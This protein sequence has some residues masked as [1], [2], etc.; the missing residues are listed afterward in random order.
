MRPS[1]AF[2]TI[3]LLAAV[4][5]L[6]DAVR[7][8]LGALAWQRVSTWAEAAA[9]VLGAGWL[10][11]Q[12]LRC[13]REKHVEARLLILPVLLVLAGGVFSYTRD[14]L[15]LQGYQ[16]S[17]IEKDAL[18][19]RQPYPLY[20]TE[21]TDI[22]LLLTMVC[23]VLLR[24]SHAH[25]EE[26]RYA[27]EYAAARQVQQVLLPG[28]LLHL[29][30]FGV[31]AEYQPAQVVGGDFYQLLGD[32]EGG[33]LV[34]VGDVAGKGLP[35]AMLVAMIVGVIRTQALCSAAP[36][37]LLR[38]L[39]GRLVGRAEGAF[40]TCLAAHLSPSGM[41]TLV[42]AGHL[43]PYLNGHELAIGGALPLGVDREAA[44]AATAVQL[45]AG[46][47]LTFLTDGV[48]EATNRNRELLGFERAE[49]LS[50]RRAGEIVQAAQD[51]GQ[52]DDVTVVTVEFQAQQAG[53]IR[54]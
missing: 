50:Q 40:S 6:L 4:V 38:V 12:L 2:R 13:T 53:Q 36:G 29:P 52:N 23:V 47:R 16:Q 49:A 11:L 14:L 43:S 22:V 1:K 27:A 41:L 39:N 7:V 19:L 33:L 5:A 25:R 42:N 8:P 28:P 21:A 54:A 10:A 44:F 17:W 9:Y 3:A 45:R 26:A 37:E 15:L 20:L 34:V 32:G 30:G 35:A 51:W 18:I 24:L 48:V 31:E 46:D